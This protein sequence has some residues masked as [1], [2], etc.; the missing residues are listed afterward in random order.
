MQ[1]LPFADRLRELGSFS[2]EKRRLCGDLAAAMRYYEGALRKDGEGLLTRECSDKTTG[3]GFNLREGSFRLDTRKKFFPVR[4]VRC[5]KKLP[6]AAVAAPCLELFKARLDGALSKLVWWKASLPTAEGLE[7]DDLEGPFQP[8]PF[9]DSIPSL[10][11]PRPANRFVV[12][13]LPFPAE[14]G[15]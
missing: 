10:F 3:N 9:D 14:E 12:F 6:R 2:R 15:E 4:S 8:K 7:L 13:S 11:L 1:H 5:W